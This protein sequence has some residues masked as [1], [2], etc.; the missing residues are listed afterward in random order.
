MKI[1]NTSDLRA[2]LLSA[3]EQV[4]DGKMGTKEALAISSLSARIMQSAQLDLRATQYAEQYNGALKNS[5]PLV[6]T[7][8]RKSLN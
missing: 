2:C 5:T 8:S 3:I 4:R 7:E 6:S 1:R